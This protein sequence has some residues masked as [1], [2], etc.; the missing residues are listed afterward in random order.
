MPSNCVARE[1][2]WESLEQQGD[3]A[4]QSQGKSTL[5]THWKDWS[6]SFSILV[7]WYEQPA[8][9]ESPWCWERLR[10][11][12]EESIRGWNGWMAS[13]MQWTWTWANCEM[14][15]DREAWHAAV[16][17]TTES[18]TTGRL[19]NHREHTNYLTILMFKKV[20]RPLTCEILHPSGLNFKQEVRP[21]GEAGG[22]SPV[23]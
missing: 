21:G 16:H 5:N 22:A 20:T 8:H 10:A 7:I 23:D 9:W 3:Q 1:D 14:V 18:D 19:N 4:S 11:E 12:G 6:W 17:E 15:R 13:Q 2:P